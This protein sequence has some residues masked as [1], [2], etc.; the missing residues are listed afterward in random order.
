M[1][2]TLWILALVLG[3]MAPPA[4]ACREIP[5]QLGELLMPG[6][7]LLFGEIHGT[8]QAPRRVADVICNAER[9]GLKMK[10]G[11]EMPTEMQGGLT[12]WLRSAGDEADRQRLLGSEF[13]QRDYQDGRSSRAMFELLEELRHS[14]AHLEL[15]AFD[16]QVPQRDRHMA[17]VVARNVDAESVLIVL[18]GNIHS[19]TRNGAPW[20]ARY[21][22]MGAV[23][24][25]RHEETFSINLG[26][27][28]GSAWVCAPECGLRELG[29]SAERPQSGFDAGVG[30]KHH[31]WNWW[32]GRASASPPATLDK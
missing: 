6:K 11:L 28:G 9:A 31:D 4:T 7:L 26:V 8:R 27:A 2:N 5:K 16:R 12:D 17:E 29:Q 1:K 14:Y 25:A 10:I 20:D 19:R 21:E 3:A 23:L 32:I 18:T 15:F 13:W 22:T 24:K 30:D